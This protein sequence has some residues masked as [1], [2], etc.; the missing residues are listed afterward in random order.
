MAQ[1][2]AL[3]GLGVE[4]IGPRLLVPVV[5]VGEDV[6]AALVEALDEDGDGVSQLSQQLVVNLFSSSSSSVLFQINRVQ[7]TLDPKFALA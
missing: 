2:G 6:V 5:P 4:G 1:T 3:L 7:L